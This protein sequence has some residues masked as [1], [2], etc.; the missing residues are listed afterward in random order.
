[1][2]ADWIDTL[3]DVWGSIQLKGFG[4]VRA[5]YLF[6]DAKFPSSIDPRDLLMNPIALTFVGERQYTYSAGGP[7]ECFYQGVTEFHVAPNLDKGLIPQIELYPDQIA[8]KA[9]ANLKLGN[10]VNNFVLQNRQDQITGPVE[11][12]Y[13]DETP[14]WGYVVY[15]EVKENLNSL[16]TVGT[17]A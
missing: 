1:M 3:Q 14:H 7:N 8:I 12:I 11:L 5:P 13:G 2:I 10:L 9:A 17:G 15:W 16:I 4:T 6:K